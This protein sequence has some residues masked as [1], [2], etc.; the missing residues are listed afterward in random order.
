MSAT[1]NDAKLKIKIRL[2]DRYVNMITVSQF[3]LQIIAFTITIHAADTV[4]NHPYR[5]PLVL[6]TISELISRWQPD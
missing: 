2:S 3:I 5:P 6:I 1:S 4:I